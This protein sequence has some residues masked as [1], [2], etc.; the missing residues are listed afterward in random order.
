MD[1]FDPLPGYVC[2][3][4]GI[5]ETKLWGWIREEP[6]DIINQASIF[7]ST[8]PSMRID[9]TQILAVAVRWCSVFDSK[10]PIQL[11]LGKTSL[12]ANHEFRARGVCQR[13]PMWRDSP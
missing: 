6:L 10:T 8:L 12:H 3:C 2:D 13:A 7:T 11:L 5:V 4:L 1:G 9:Q